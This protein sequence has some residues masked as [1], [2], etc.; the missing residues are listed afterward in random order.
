MNDNYFPIFLCF[1]KQALPE[2]KNQSQR[3]CP[4][5]NLQLENLSL[6]LHQSNKIRIFNEDKETDLL[7]FRSGKATFYNFSLSSV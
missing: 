5:N 6:S 2:F 3:S 1:E 4:E 7:D